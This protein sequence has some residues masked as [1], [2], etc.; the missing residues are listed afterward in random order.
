MAGVKEDQFTDSTRQLLTRL[1]LPLIKQISASERDLKLY[2]SLTG[3]EEIT[4]E[5]ISIIEERLTQERADLQ[6]LRNL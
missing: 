2:K 4:K 5:L 6:Q 3:D 1:Q